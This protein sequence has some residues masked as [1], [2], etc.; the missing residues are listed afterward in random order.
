MIDVIAGP[1]RL[2][3]TVGETEDEHILDGLFSQVVVDTVDL[4]FLEYLMCDF[5][6]M[7]SGLEVVSKR[8]LNHDPSPT[9][10]VFHHTGFT[11]S[12]ER[13]FVHM[14]RRRQIVKAAAAILILDLSQAPLE[15]LHRRLFIKVTA[16]VS[17]FAGELAP[18]IGFHFL[19]C[20]LVHR[21]THV[22]AEGFV[23][24]LGP[25]HPKDVKLVRQA[26][27]AVQAEQGRDQ[28]TLREIAGGAEDHEGD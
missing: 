5:V 18:R 11:Q 20:E 4:V 6:Q 3:N 22:V 25:R 17:E 9:V 28:F 7:L 14:W 16:H 23:G 8:F 1:D 2:K 13:G 19:R 21:L 15:F 10:V 27:L 26:V 12:T 24:R